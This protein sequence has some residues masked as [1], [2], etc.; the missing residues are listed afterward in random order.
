MCPVCFG[1]ATWYLA[2]ASSAGGIAALVLKRSS[3]QNKDK[4]NDACGDAES[5]RDR[6]GNALRKQHPA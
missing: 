1:V 5:K 6:K 4:H 2:S 3:G